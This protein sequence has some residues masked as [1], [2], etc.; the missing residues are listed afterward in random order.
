MAK[1]VEA[2]PDWLTAVQ[3]KD[4]YSVS[5]C[6][7]EDFSAYVCDWTVIYSKPNGWWLFDTP[8]VIREF[9]K[10]HSIDIADT[11]LFFYEFYEREYD[12]DTKLWKPFTSD[13]RF[14]TDVH[15]PITKTLEGYDV[16]SFSGRSMPECSP[17]SCNSLA[18]EIETN[19]H[20]LLPSFDC[21]KELLDEGRFVR[22]E[23]GPYRIFAV[24]SVPWPE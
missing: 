3:V 20:C 22:C 15:P 13:T 23:P 16:V 12:E 4:I 19:E 6:V 14:K 1:R 11:K 24:Y 18:C 2:R 17:L 7:S 8:D 5:S 9:A 21:A 10:G